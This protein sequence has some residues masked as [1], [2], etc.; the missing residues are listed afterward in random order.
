MVFLSGQIPIDPKTG[1]LSKGSIEEQTK[2]VLENLKSVLNAA[3]LTFADV[4]ST[5]CFLKN[6]DDFPKVSASPSPP[7][8]HHIPPVL[9][10]RLLP[11]P[12]IK[13][14]DGEWFWEE[15]RKAF[16]LPRDYIHSNWRRTESGDI[17]IGRC[18]T[19]ATLPRRFRRGGGGGG[20]GTEACKMLSA[21]AFA[22][23][24]H[25]EAFLL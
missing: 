22:G 17:E 14:K 23:V 25:P 3:G 9:H 4:L 6:M 7:G 19:E 24:T 11:H 21:P 10:D 13:A 5:N 12:R 8:R 16:I 18:P 2:L 15:V 20:P 1:E